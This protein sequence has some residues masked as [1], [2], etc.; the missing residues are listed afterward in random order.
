MQDGA[1]AAQAAQTQLAGAPPMAPPEEQ[2][3][4][5]AA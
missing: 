5:E 4:K 3:M 1:F 2:A